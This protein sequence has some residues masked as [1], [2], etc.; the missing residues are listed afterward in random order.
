LGIAGADLICATLADRSMPG[1]AD[2]DWRAF[3]STTSE[4]A[5][6]RIGE[7]PWYDREGR[8]VAE[9]IDGLLNNRPD[10][11]PAIVDDLPNE[12]GIP[13]SAPE[14]ESLDNHDT[15]T[16]S[17]EDGRLVMGERGGGAFGGGNSSFSTCMDW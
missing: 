17:D 5:I 15:M 1:A 8:L 3:L 10:G 11:D 14:G 13:N 12:W 7:G 4:D 16:G 6:D 9:D 2:K